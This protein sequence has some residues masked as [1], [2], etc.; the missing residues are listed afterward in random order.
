[1]VGACG[2]AREQR[3]PHAELERGG[4]GE[5]L[6]AERAEHGVEAR[7]A[8]GEGGVEE[9]LQGAARGG[10][11]ADQKPP[12]ESAGCAPQREPQ[13]LRPAGRSE[14]R[15]RRACHER[16]EK[17]RAE[18]GLPDEVLVPIEGRVYRLNAAFWRHSAA[19]S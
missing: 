16:E 9:E 4:E 18:A 11:E 12:L 10:G 15:D 3:S 2:A 17:A 6:R 1:M 14:R 13:R 8:N 19:F 5:E 7:A